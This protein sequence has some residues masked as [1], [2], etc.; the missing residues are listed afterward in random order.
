[1]SRS[2]DAPLVSIAIPVFNGAET[3]RPTIESALN[4]DHSNL[5][6]VISDNASTD[7]TE[8]MCRSYARADSRVVYR[9]HPANVG[10][11]NN[12]RSVAEAAQGSFVRWLGDAD[13]LEPDYVSRSLQAFADD[14]RRVLVTT[15]MGYVDPAG[16]V[17]F[18][19]DYDSVALSSSD[20]VER[21]VEM[22]RLLTS[23]FELLD[24]LYAMMR[25]H[26]AVL[27]R[28]NILREDEVFAARLALAGPWGHVA[29]PLARRP[30]SEVPT[31]ALARLLGVP[32]WM[33][34]A[35]DL[36]QCRELQFWIE[37]SSL[38]QAQRRRARAEVVRM[39]ARRKRNTVRRGVAKLSRAAG[40]PRI[41]AARQ[42]Q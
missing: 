9:R 13:F 40:P 42:T 25:R 8:S 16:S 33:G 35:A 34:Y 22:L 31:P 41:R 15:Q 3:L 17:S 18:G 23:G 2:L 4:Q 10:L 27:P 26:V 21:F 19:P 28:R 36:L 39:Y 12:F 37:R 38:D 30:R 1:M 6:V 11:L 29:A 24:P 7:G 5:Q 14:E 32:A 20:P